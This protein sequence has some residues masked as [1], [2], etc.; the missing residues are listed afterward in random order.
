MCEVLGVQPYK[1]KYKFGAGETKT[2]L[3]LGM[4]CG[5]F[6]YTM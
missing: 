4:E 2:A 1:A 5:F 3:L 6:V